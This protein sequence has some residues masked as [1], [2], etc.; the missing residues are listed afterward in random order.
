[1]YSC[2]KNFTFSVTMLLFPLKSSGAIQGKVPRTPPETKVCC[3][4]FDK[5]RSPIYRDIKECIR[6]IVVANIYQRPKN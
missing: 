3:F 2:F 5:P 1:M 4:T 6:Q